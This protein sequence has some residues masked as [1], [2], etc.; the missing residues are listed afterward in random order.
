[1]KII[2]LICVALLLTETISSCTTR[3]AY[4]SLRLNRELECQNLQGADQQECL[5][6]TGMSYDEYQ[7][8]LK[9]HPAGH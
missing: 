3:T 6:R 9:E 8:Q 1:M 5:R 4:D 7:R 2:P